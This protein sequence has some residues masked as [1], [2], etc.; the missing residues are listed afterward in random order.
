MLLQFWRPSTSET[1]ARHAS[2][3]A[4]QPID[5]CLRI[6]DGNRVAFLNDLVDC[7]KGFECLNFI[8]E[9]WLPMQFE[10]AVSI[11]LVPAVEIVIELEVLNVHFHARPEGLGGLM[12]PCVDDAC[13]D[14]LPCVV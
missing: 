11:G 10:R 12:V 13:S 8:G 2:C 6:S 9:Y 3:Q 4:F 1:L 5:I 7:N 14:M